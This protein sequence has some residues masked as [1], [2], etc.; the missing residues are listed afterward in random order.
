MCR[1]V[2]DF[3]I[4]ILYPVTLLFSLSSSSNFLVA[5]LGFSMYS[6]TSSA[7]SKSFTYSFLIWIDFFFFFFPLIAVARP[8]KTILNNS[9]YSGH[10]GL[11]PDLSGDAFRFPPFQSLLSAYHIWPLPC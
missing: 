4:L 8:S 9:G 7:N 1:N 2:K 11:V 5:S 3:C 10:H 6:I